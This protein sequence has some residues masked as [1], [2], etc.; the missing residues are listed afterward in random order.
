MK[1]HNKLLP[2]SLN[3]L[4]EML[5]PLAIRTKSECT[6]AME[7]IDKLA[8]LE[9]R[10]PAQNR[11]LETLT[12]LVEAYEQEHFEAQLNLTDPLHPLRFSKH[13]KPVVKIIPPDQEVKNPFGCMRGTIT[14]VGDIAK[15][16]DENWHADVGC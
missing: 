9:K 2:R 11:Y 16:T 1:S 7:V 14:I 3:G 10:S 5:V 15:P 13:G 8:V 6:R 12:I 4:L